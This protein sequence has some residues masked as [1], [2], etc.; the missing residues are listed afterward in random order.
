MKTTGALD[1][2]DCDIAALL[3]SENERL[4]KQDNLFTRSKKISVISTLKSKDGEATCVS[5]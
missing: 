4:G 1:F 3:E 5:W 2:Q